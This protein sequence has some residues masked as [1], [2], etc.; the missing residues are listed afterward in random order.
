MQLNAY[1]SFNGN[2]EEAFRYYE[3]HLG[4][5]IEGMFPFEGSPMEGDMPPDWK[6]KIMH[7]SLRIGDEVLMGADPPPAHYSKPQG[8][9]VSISVK[10]PAEA[11]RIF[12]ALADGGEVAMPIAETFWAQRFGMVTDRF[13]A[14]WM[15][16]CE[17]PV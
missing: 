11:E 12:A 8:V 3:K 16:N 5:K 1:L 10:D 6:K 9:S 15:V 13:G 14:P 2:C 17:K 4:G 7:A